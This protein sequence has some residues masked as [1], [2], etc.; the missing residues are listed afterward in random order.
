MHELMNRDYW[1]VTNILIGNS[2]L[3]RITLLHWNKW[4]SIAKLHS[5]SEYSNVSVNYKSGSMHRMQN[6]KFQRR[7]VAAHLLVFLQQSFPLNARRS[8]IIHSGENQLP[9][10]PFWIFHAC[11]IAQAEIVGELFDAARRNVNARVHT[12]QFRHQ[13]NT[14]VLQ[15][16]Y[17][18]IDYFWREQNE[19]K[20]PSSWKTAKVPLSPSEFS[21][22]NSRIGHPSKQSTIKIFVDDS[23]GNAES[24]NSINHRLPPP[25]PF[26]F[27][28]SLP[29]DAHRQRGIWRR[30]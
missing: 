23:V 17:F 15:I 24:E 18:L 2:I 9:V 19:T 22:T 10:F 25:S 3:G 6:L 11:I 29:A 8:F 21:V 28:R 5:R 20:N 27:S 13:G 12:Q 26:P 30:G 4:F 14:T 16:E 7:P 1:C